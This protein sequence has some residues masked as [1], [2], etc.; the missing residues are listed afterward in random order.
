MQ[1]T[2]S[3]RDTLKYVQRGSNLIVNNQITVLNPTLADIEEYG[4]QKYVSEVAA[5]VMRPYDAAVMLDDIG[6]DYLTV[7][8]YDFFLMTARLTLANGALILPGLHL[9]DAKV[10]TNPENGQTILYDPEG[11]YVIDELAYQ[12]IVDYVRMIHF[13]PA[14]V[15]HDVANGAAKQFLLRNM[16]SKMRRRKNK[17]F[18]SQYSPIISALVNSAGFKYNY[19]S[20]WSLHVSQIWDAFYRA[21][22]IQSYQNTMLGIYTG[23]ID[24][25]KID[26]DVLSWFGRIDPNASQ[27]ADQS[28]ALSVTQ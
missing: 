18:E 25:K 24:S 16:R 12:Q 19:D 23:N 9:K 10:G 8:D 6:L 5:I 17:Q 13:I 20:V 21:N 2:A 14:R 22:K 4:E 3:V 7:R 1:S 27:P 15:E 28:K 11:K 26:K